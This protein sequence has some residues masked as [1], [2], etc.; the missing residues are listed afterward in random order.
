MW[1]RTLSIALGGALGALARFALSGWIN[2]FSYM[3]SGR[4]GAVFPWGTLAVNLAGCLGIG[5]LAGIFHRRVVAPELRALLLIGFL[6]G[7]TTFSTF[8]LESLELVRGGSTGLALANALGSP[9]LG[10][11]GVWLGDALSRLL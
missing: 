3:D 8:A 5:L 2:S 10:L 9:L 11:A 4:P 7:F 1:L 6:G